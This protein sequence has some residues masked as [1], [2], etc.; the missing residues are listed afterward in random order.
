M[1]AD[2]KMLLIRNYDLWC[3]L[4]DED[5]EA[6]N[7][8]H[9]FIEAKKGSYIY[10]EAF[11]HNK[12]YFIKEGYIRIGFIDEEGNEVIKEIIQQGELFGQITLEKNNLNGEFAQ[13]Y[14]ADVSLCAFNVEDF[15]KLLGRKPEI[16]LKYTRQVGNK[17]KTVENRL[18][19][20]LNKDVKSRL[21]HFFWQ[22]I[23]SAHEYNNTSG[24]YCIPNYFT[25]EDIAHMVGSSRQTITSLINELATDKILSYNRQQICFPDVKK[26][27]KLANVM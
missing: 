19:N 3:H 9:H 26:I 10:F 2:K 13:A 5:Y 16:A 8:V 12:L 18:L 1:T 14:K 11:N 22:L 4:S 20:L 7:L 24:V 6:L 21:L 23:Q 25:H 17:L 15:E 27:Q